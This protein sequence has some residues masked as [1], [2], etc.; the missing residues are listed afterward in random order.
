MIRASVLER[1]A[2][3]LGIDYNRG[4]IKKVNILKIMEARFLTV[5]KCKNG[6]T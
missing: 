6:E 4:L 5:G 1:G 2:V 3:E